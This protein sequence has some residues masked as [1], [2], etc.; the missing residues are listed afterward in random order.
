MKNISRALGRGSD[1]PLERVM[2]PLVSY[3]CATERPKAALASA[4]AALFSAVEETN[5][6]ARACVGVFAE[7]T[8]S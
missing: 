6:E 2:E 7:N 4:V 5:R 3:I 8:S 1:N